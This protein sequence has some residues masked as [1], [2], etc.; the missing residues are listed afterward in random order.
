MSNPFNTSCSG[1]ILFVLV[2]VSDR[3]KLRQEA[4]SRFLNSFSFMCQIFGIMRTQGG[5]VFKPLVGP[6]FECF[7]LILDDSNCDPD[8]YEV[9]NEQVSYNVTRI[10]MKFSMNK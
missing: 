10:S 7:T 4:S 3:D 5:E 1:S 6:V 9:F 8:Q 2:L